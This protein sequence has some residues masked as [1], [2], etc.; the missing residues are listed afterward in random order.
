MQ[1]E[2]WFS[3]GVQMGQYSE[4]EHVIVHISDTHYLADRARLYGKVDTDSTL[5]LA[6]SQLERSGMRPD[7]IVVTGDVADRGEP[8]AYRRTRALIEPVAKRI[9]AELLWVMGNHDDRSAFRVDLLG[10]QP[11]IRPLDHVITVNGLRIVAL[12][13]SVPGYHHGELDKS[14]LEWLRAVL[15]EDAPHGTLLALHHPPLPTPL[16]LMTV[17][18]LQHQERLADAIRGSDVRGILAGHLHYATTGLFAGIPVSVAAATSYTMDLTAPER[19]LSGIS[20]GQSFNLTLVY[21]EQVVHSVVPITQAETVTHFDEN[22]LA[23]VESL[24]HAGRIEAFSRFLSA[25]DLSPDA[26]EEK[27]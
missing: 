5:E 8:D 6:I 10:E 1:S 20:G 7:A 13:S 23:K 19:E 11:S 22:F 12:D 14:Q 18:E 9:G 15:S 16:R 21:A 17:L 25:E 27:G 3:V 4:P 2:R 26:P 24:D